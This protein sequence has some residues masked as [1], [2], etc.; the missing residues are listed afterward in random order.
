MYLHDS[1]VKDLERRMLD[2]VTLPHL[3]W[4]LSAPQV[5]LQAIILEDKKEDA[6]RIYDVLK[7]IKSPEATPRL[8]QAVL[9][10][11]TTALE[12]LRDARAGKLTGL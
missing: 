9:S 11:M 1:V 2:A 10:A 5:G 7:R 3:D 4:V 12:L 8:E 6:A